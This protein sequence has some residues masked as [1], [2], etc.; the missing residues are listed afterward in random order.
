MNLHN[1]D[2]RSLLDPEQWVRNIVSFYCYGPFSVHPHPERS[3]M[4]VLADHD[5]FCWVL[6]R[7]AKELEEVVELAEMHYA[8]IILTQGTKAEGL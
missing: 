2:R 7:S 3:G 5:G 8:K 4:F 1:Y 6:G